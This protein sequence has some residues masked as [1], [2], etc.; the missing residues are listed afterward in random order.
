MR[1][2]SGQSTCLRVL[3]HERYVIEANVTELHSS[4]GMRVQVEGWI[5]FP[6]NSANP[7][8]NPGGKRR[9]LLRKVSRRVR[10]WQDVQVG[11]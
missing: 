11:V 9:A 5:H 6:S 1:Q 8:L 7:T 10:V 2:L 4:N 3:Q